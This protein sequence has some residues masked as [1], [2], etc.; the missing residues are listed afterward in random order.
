VDPKAL[1]LSPV[2]EMPIHNIVSNLVYAASGHEVKTVVVAGKVLVR[3]GVVLTANEDAV[4]AEAQARA[5]MVAQ[6]ASADPVHKGMALMEEMEAG[7]LKRPGTEPRCHIV[8]L[9]P[10]GSAS[11]GAPTSAPD[12][13]QL[14]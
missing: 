3:D 7:W 14:G 2:L 5:E 4:R 9:T 10:V 12:G 6:N 8:G 13:V 1:N 11:H